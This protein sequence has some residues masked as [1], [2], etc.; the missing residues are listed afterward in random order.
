MRVAIR[1]GA[2]ALLLAS[3]RASRRGSREAT[4]SK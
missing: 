3:S 1:V 4:A 2:I